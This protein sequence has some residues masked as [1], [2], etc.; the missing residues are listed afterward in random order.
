MRVLS[1][2]IRGKMA[3]FR[4]YYS[5]TSALSY[6]VPP[7]T[8]VCGMIAGLLGYE[9]NQYYELFLQDRCNITVGNLCSIKKIN[10]KMNLLMIKSSRDF[11]GSEYYSQ[12]PT[13][14]IL[15]V[16]VRNSYL[17]YKIW[18]HHSS[19]AIMDELKS[20]LDYSDGFNSKG[21]ALALGKAKFQ[22]WVEKMEDLQ[23]FDKVNGEEM[24]AISSVIPVKETNGLDLQDSPENSFLLRE[25][26][27]LEFNKDR[28]LQKKGDFILNV[29]G[30]KIKANVN[31][32]VKLNNGEI[33]AWMED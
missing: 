21:T 33:I 11:R 5:N 32:A 25:D 3:H 4:C 14:V 13:E 30:G 29:R 31:T 23:L 17:D 6:M 20:L 18:F 12:T 15:P 16:D 7:R 26:L 2:H 1:F 8:T 22:G 24:L 27:P 10:Q 28:E 19:N 9:K